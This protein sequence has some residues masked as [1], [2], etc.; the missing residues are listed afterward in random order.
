MLK[1]LSPAS[2]GALSAVIAVVCFSINDVAIKFLSGGYALHQVV[3]FRSLIGTTFLLAVILPL[4]GGWRALRTRRPAMHLL[5]GLC[6]VFANMTF[7]LGLATLPLAEGVAIFF[8]SPLIITVMSVVFLGERVGP[9]RWGAVAVGLLGVVVVLRPGSA[10]FQFASLLPI[11]AAFGYAA[12]HMLTRAI[13]KTESTVALSFY[14][15]LTFVIVT[16]I[17]GLAMGDG[18]YATTSHPSLEFLFRAW[19]MPDPA[20][21]AVLLLVGLASALGGFFI[22]HAYRISE[23]AVVAPFEYLALPLSVLWGVLVF[24]DW[25]DGWTYLGIALILG[26]GLTIIWR[27]AVKGRARHPQSPRYRR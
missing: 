19:R 24:A 20:D 16:L 9:F 13:G 7:F 14:I 25:P 10:A 6:V 21:W 27:E 2:V 15:Q 8:V 3:L 18:R 23:A 5:R 22:S 17:L 1:D 12:L 4:S 26:A 11:A